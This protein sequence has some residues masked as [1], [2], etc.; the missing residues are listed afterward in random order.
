MEIPLCICLFIQPKK[1]REREKRDPIYA[2][3]P[4]SK[5]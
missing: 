5:K 2:C 4:I 3:K 1:E